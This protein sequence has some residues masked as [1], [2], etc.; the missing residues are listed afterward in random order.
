MVNQPALAR[1]ALFLIVFTLLI[2]P[3]SATSTILSEGEF[4]EMV[5]DDPTLEYVWNIPLKLI[6]LDFVFMTA[7]LLFLPVQLVA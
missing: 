1:F 4:P 5:P 2:T 6:L 7:P 3:G